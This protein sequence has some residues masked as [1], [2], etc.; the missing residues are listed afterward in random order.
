MTLQTGGLDS[1]E[2]NH[3][4]DWKRFWWTFFCFQAVGIAGGVSGSIYGYGVAIV[5][6][7]PGGIPAIFVASSLNQDFSLIMACLLAVVFNA[8]IWVCIHLI[9][10]RFRK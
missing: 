3:K 9:V 6:L 7:L 4:S 8:I 5:M 1:T 2:V 10:L